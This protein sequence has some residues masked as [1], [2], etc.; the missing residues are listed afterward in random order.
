MAK[1]EDYQRLILP[2]LPAAYNLARWLT[3]DAASAEDRGT[4]LFRQL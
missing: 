4:D 3:R 2:H 1:R